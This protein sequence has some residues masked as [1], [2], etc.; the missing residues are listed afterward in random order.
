MLF[1]RK[2]KKRI[3]KFFYS[4]VTGKYYSPTIPCYVIVLD[5]ISKLPE[6]SA[7]FMQ[8]SDTKTDDAKK[9]KL[10]VKN[11]QNPHKQ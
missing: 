3:N 1:N 10:S 8:C 7:I 4:S 11:I 2:N 6:N 9:K 5:I